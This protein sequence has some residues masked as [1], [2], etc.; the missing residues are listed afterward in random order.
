MIRRA[1]RDRKLRPVRVR[2][3]SERGRGNGD[4]QKYPGTHGFQRDVER[5]SC[6]RRKTRAAGG[7]DSFYEICEPLLKRAPVSLTDRARGGQRRHRV[8]EEA[9]DIGLGVAGFELHLDGV[10]DGHELA[11]AL[12]AE[13][14]D[15][16]L[17]RLDHAE[18]CS[19]PPGDSIQA[20]VGLDVSH[21]WSVRLETRKS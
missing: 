8:G 11:L 9:H 10:D 1:T 5:I 2:H 6:I 12:E 16:A 14:N 18:G 17:D 3:P 21:A 19:V 15:G 20:V 13:A 4:A 7:C